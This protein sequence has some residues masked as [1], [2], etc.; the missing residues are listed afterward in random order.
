[1]NYYEE[2]KSKLLDDEIYAKVKDY[3]KEEHRLTTY[4]EVGKILFEVGSIY[5]D[6]IIGKYAEKLA[7]E[8]GKKYNKKTLFKMRQFY[9][10]FSNEKVAPVARHL[11]W[12]HCLMLLPL[13]DIDEINYY[14]N[15]VIKRNLSKRQLQSIIKSNEYERLPEDTKKKLIIKEELDT[16]S[17][18]KNPIQIKSNN[19]EIISEKILQRLILEDIPYFL[20]ELYLENIY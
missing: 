9:K 3:S 17:L 2:I 13:K 5:G 7:V 4:F 14:I 6:N 19:H 8:I 15:Q 1:M 10:I 11:N 16:T 12:S 20:E 18:V